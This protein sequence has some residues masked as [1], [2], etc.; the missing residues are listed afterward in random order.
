V[1][2]LGGPQAIVARGSAKISV[3][4]GAVRKAAMIAELLATKTHH[5]TEASWRAISCTASK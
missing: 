1:Q 4:T 5:P 3:A 2:V